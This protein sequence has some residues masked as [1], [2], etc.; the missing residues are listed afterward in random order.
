MR[1]GT[2]V[3][4]SLIAVSVVLASP[5]G[6]E[7]VEI[8]GVSCDHVD[9]GEPFTQREDPVPSWELPKPSRA[10]RASGFMLYVT[11][12]PGD[13]RP[14]GRP[15]VSQRRQKLHTFLSK[16][17]DEP[18]WF[19]IYALEDIT[20]LTVEA[21][22]AASGCETDVRHMHFWPQRTG[23][24]SR[25]WYVTPELLLPCADGHRLVPA[26]R[27]VLEREPFDVP[28]G[29]T[30]AF[31][32]TLSS[33]LQAQPGVHSDRVV[34]RA[35]GRPPLVVPLK[36]EILP[37][38]LTRPPQRSW[39]LYADVARWRNMADDQVMAEL[40]DFSR[41]GMN[42][43]VEVPLGSADLT[44]LREGRVTFD[45]TP[46][47]KLAGMCR[48]AGLTGPHVCPLGGMAYRVRDALGL[49]CDVATEPWPEALKKGLAAVAT[50]AVKATADVDA[51]WLFYG[52]DEP[53]G[54]NLYAIQEYECWRQGGAR[55][56][57]TF[58]QLG[59]LEQ[60]SRFLTAP[61]FVAGLIAREP[62]ARE[63]LEG[64]RAGGAELWWYG[65]GSYVNPAPQEGLMF[66]NRYGAG[67]LF[68]KSRARAQVTW[69]FCRPH[70][71]VFNDFDGSRE[72]H[73]EPKE[74]ATA[75]PHLLKADDWSTY[76]GAI[77][78]IAWESLREGVDD[79]S[80]LYMAQQAIEAARRDGGEAGARAADS[81]QRTLDSLVASVPWLNPLSWE[82]IDTARLQQV[83]RVAAD[84]AVR[85]SAIA[86][87]GTV[88]PAGPK[89]TQRIR[90]CLEA[91]EPSVHSARE[92]RILP[93]PPT[94]VAPAI[95]GDLGDP[96]WQAA[97]VATPFLNAQDGGA[98]AMVSSA[99][100]LH[101]PE[102]VYVAFRCGETRP[103]LLSARVTGR[104]PDGIWLEDSVEIFLAGKDPANYIHLIVGTEGALYD[105]HRQ[106]PA[107]NGNLKVAAGRQPGAWTVEVFLPWNDLAKAGIDQG[108]VMRGNLCRNR[109]LGGEAH[110]H[111]AWSPTFGG[112]HK[113]S[114]FGTLAPQTGPIVLTRLRVPGLWGDQALAAA[115]RNTSDQRCRVRIA[116]SGQTGEE[117]GVPPG[118][119]LRVSLPVTLTTIG[120]WRSTL[121]WSV[122]DEASHR[123]PVVADVPSPIR[124]LEQVWFVGP[125]D[126]VRVPVQVNLPPTM[127]KRCRITATV[128]DSERPVA[129][130]RAQPGKEDRVCLSVAGMQE[131]RVSLRDRDTGNVLHTEVG[132][133]FV[134]PTP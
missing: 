134:L 60:A 23:W 121:E 120:P 114:H 133:I 44:A 29:R 2:H 92:M 58:Y 74:Q 130:I 102:G 36:T 91:R 70:E 94:D 65:T 129:A 47:R 126:S 31:W 96:C 82:R 53:R 6:A 9:P 51:D 97:A 62:Q 54:D 34:I 5:T 123:M 64:C 86:D 17:E 12:D 25:Q 33:G 75:Y 122:A 32:L 72:N 100:V 79:Y 40:R 20:G 14:D 116:L 103:D 39:L 49:T 104:D 59:F 67:C 21:D 132:H 57:A 107:W 117:H 108:G 42:G 46:F 19:A 81:A 16:G 131:L 38:Q 89:R 41:H 119:E 45:A 11:S 88:G 50:A 63:A 7:P 105:E 127:A 56:Y 109:Y 95:D 66:P 85:L 111:T 1:P 83:R 115:L 84:V 27:G 112:F 128:G 30:A 8:S 52:V 71:D 24:R 124:L 110:P 77:P 43:L 3:A 13:V 113:P 101:G 118:D 68:W 15:K 61:C 98:T 76:Q 80:Y 73:A 69:T 78:T 18:L 22:T 87:R 99:L 48:N 37:L 28:A 90:V 93:V 106:E 35:A 125:G 10:E 26:S 4:W 55:T